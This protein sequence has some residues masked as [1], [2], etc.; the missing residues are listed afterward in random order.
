MSEAFSAPRWHTIRPRPH[1][2]GASAAG[3]QWGP[4]ASNGWA[5]CSVCCAMGYVGRPGGA[6]WIE[7]GDQHLAPP[8]RERLPWF[9]MWVG[10]LIGGQ[11]VAVIL[12]LA[13]RLA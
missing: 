12:W 1:V 3:H 6:W 8:Q 5:Q 13:G 9:W 4:P 2:C 10:F 11:V 7:A